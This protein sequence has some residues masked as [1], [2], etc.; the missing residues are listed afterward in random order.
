[1]RC[2][3]EGYRWTYSAETKDR[4]ASIVTRDSLKL[5]MILLRDVSGW[6]DV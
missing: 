3:G 4:V 1:M 5:S 2:V 6:R